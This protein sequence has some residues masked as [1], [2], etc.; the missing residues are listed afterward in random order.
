[1]MYGLR[2]FCF[3]ILFLFLF[4][5][6]RRQVR[7][8]LLVESNACYGCFNFSLISWSIL[9]PMAIR[10]LFFLSRINKFK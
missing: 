6:G 5:N 10:S 7:Y 8:A 9:H 1:M 2:L 3:A 4:S